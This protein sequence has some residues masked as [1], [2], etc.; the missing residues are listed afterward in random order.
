L[1]EIGCGFHGGGVF[2][3]ASGTVALSAMEKGLLGGSDVRRISVPE[4]EGWLLECA[5]E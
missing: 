1:G 2:T 3:A 5:A 4:V